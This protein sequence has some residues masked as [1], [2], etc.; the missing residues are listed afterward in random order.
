VAIKP[1]KGQIRYVAGT[2]I[3][4]SKRDDRLYAAVVVLDALTLQIVET[5]FHQEKGCFPYISGLLAFR[6]IPPLLTAFQKLR[7]CPDVVMCDGQGI[8]HPRKLGLAAHLGLWLQ[9]PTLGCAKTRLVGE[10]APFSLDKGKQSALYYKNQVIGAVFC[11]KNNVKPLFIS[12]GHLIDIE[13]SV[14]LIQK[15]LS[16]WRLPEPTRQAHLA[17]NRLRLCGAKTLS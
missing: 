13:G 5:A 12:P 11:S 4:Y 10:F 17:G 6:E 1:L 7:L 2:D 16:R 9:I 8:A 14:A 15:C 3:S